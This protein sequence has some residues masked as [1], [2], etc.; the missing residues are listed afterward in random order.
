MIAN[1]YAN[2][3]SDILYYLRNITIHHDENDDDDEMPFAMIS[4]STTPGFSEIK[5][6]PN[7]ER[8]TTEYGS[9]LPTDINIDPTLHLD[10]SFDE[11]RILHS[12]TLQYKDTSITSYT[13]NTN[14]INV[15]G[16]IFEPDELGI[17]RMD[18]NIYKDCDLSVFDTIDGWW[19]DKVYYDNIQQQPVIDFEYDESFVYYGVIV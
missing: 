6:I 11:G 18:N 3:L 17:N 7:T 13:A 4:E 8:S 5:E 2:R 12:L 14:S 19:V 1:N 10:P 9:E 15:D 16:K